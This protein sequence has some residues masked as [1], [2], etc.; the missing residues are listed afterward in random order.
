[1]PSSSS[2]YGRV[3]A[4]SNKYHL[5]NTDG[6]ITEKNICKLKNQ[7]MCSTHAIDQMPSQARSSNT[8]LTPMLKILPPFV[9][10][11]L[12]IVIVLNKVILDW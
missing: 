12:T 1:M 10:A 3:E 2:P 6:L 11:D 9:S 5:A 8:F 7:A 4:Y